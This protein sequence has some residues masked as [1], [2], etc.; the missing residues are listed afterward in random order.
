MKQKK[1][2]KI[3]LSFTSPEKENY[4]FIIFK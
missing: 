3:A 2:G 1:R 4:L